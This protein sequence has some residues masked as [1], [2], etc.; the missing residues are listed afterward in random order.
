VHLDKDGKI[1]HIVI[2]MRPTPAA[3]KFAVAIS[4]RLQPTS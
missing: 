1:D 2:Y 4:Q 3:Q